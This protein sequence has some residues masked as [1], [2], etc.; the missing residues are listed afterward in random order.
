[1]PDHTPHQR[2]IIRRYYEHRDDL[3]LQ[4]L[5]EL[6]SDL[7]LAENDGERDRLWKR[8][9]AALLNLKLPAA[10]V[11][12]LLERRDPKALARLIEGEF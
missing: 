5:A 11:R 1:V 10:R 8:V 2:G 7:Y 6:V 12:A 9:E 3:M 4:K